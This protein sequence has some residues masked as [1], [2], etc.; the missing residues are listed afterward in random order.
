MSKQKLRIRLKKICEANPWLVGTIIKEKQRHE[1][2]MCSFPNTIT[3]KDIDAVF[4]TEVSGSID[5]ISSSTSL[6]ETAKILQK[7][8]AMCESGYSVVNKP[9]RV[10]KVSL[11]PINGY[12]EFAF[13]FPVSHLMADGYT[14]YKLLSMLADC[15]PIGSLKVQRLDDVDDFV[16][17]TIGKAEKELLL[18]MLIQI[19]L[20][21][22]NKKPKRSKPTMTQTLLCLPMV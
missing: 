18:R 12:K 3:D 16:I 9:D 2:L 8:G 17:R 20:P 5:M 15:S 10:L 19:G 6:E 14:S 22:P 13:V 4:W 11:F 1:R 7:P 21:Q